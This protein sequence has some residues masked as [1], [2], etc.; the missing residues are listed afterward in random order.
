MYHM[1]GGGIHLG[2]GDLLT[3]GNY[4]FFNRPD[5]GSDISEIIQNQTPDESFVVPQRIHL[6]QTILNIEV[7]LS[8]Y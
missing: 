3:H 7:V 2:A 8:L 5:T 4:F 1:R 6:H